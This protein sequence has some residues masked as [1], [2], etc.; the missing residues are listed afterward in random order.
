MVMVDLKAGVL[1]LEANVLD[2]QVEVLDLNIVV[3]SRRQWCRRWC[4]SEMIR[5]N[6]E[7]D[8]IK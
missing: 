8:E 4:W 7:R 2:L 3:H 1:D 6:T 5:D